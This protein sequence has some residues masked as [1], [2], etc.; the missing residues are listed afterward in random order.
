MI[1]YLEKKKDVKLKQ[2]TQTNQK[3]NKCIFALLKHL[4]LEI[5][6]LRIKS[7]EMK[8]IKLIVTIII[9]IYLFKTEQ[10]RIFIKRFCS[11]C[12]LRTWY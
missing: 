7:N 5:V 1:N 9:I 3:E 10:F 12:T 2:K 11:S 4:Y 8:I 6:I